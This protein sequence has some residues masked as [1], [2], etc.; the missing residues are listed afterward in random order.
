ML[1][2]PRTPDTGLHLGRLGISRPAS[3][4]SF[5]EVTRTSAGRAAPR[6]REGWTAAGRTKRH[7]RTVIGTPPWLGR[8]QAWTEIQLAGG[9]PFDDQHDAGAGWTAEAGCL[10]RIDAFRHAEQ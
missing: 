9:E 7:S 10:W 8:G 6:R 5:S 3:P 4:W 2:A 1:R